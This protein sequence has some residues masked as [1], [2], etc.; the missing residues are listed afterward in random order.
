VIPTF[1][2]YDEAPSL[3]PILSVFCTLDGKRMPG[4]EG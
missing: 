1:P 2:S 3:E 4:S